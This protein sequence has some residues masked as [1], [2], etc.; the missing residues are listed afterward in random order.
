MIDPIAVEPIVQT[1]S[2]V[3]VNVYPEANGG[4]LVLDE[5]HVHT[6]IALGVGL[7]VVSLIAFF[8]APWLVEK[9]KEDANTSPPRGV[10][11]AEW[12]NATR[13]DHPWA[14]KALGLLEIW[15]FFVAFWIS[16][17]MLIGGWL[18]FKLGSKWQAWSSIVR[19]PKRF[20]EDGN[21]LGDLG[22]RNRWASV[23]LQAYLIGTLT[24]V[25]GGFIGM[26][27]GR[28]IQTLLSP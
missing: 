14:T 5:L 25:A 20:S 4:I 24:N 3:I 28:L 21:V 17:P 8:F 9:V 11:T 15:V 19:V 10:T 27:I 26:W 12:E 23:L 18:A 22:A 16:Q 2:S 13:A 7:L 1:L 6:G